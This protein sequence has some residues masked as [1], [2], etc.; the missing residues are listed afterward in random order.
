M[1]TRRLYW[2]LTGPSFAVWEI[3]F[4]HRLGFLVNKNVNLF[5][6]GKNF[7]VTLAGRSSIRRYKVGPLNPNPLRQS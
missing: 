5:V 4:K 2:I 1:G 3:L 6:W 7:V